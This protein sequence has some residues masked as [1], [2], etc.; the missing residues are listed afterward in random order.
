MRERRM[1]SLLIEP[2]LIVRPVR[3]TILLSLR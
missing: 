1:A 3:A 2:G